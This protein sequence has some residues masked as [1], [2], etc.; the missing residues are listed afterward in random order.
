MTSHTTP[1]SGFVIRFA[2]ADDSGAAADVA[3]LA[4]LD[5]VA[6]SPAAPY[7]IAERDGL[8]VAA[9]SLSEGVTVAN[10]FLPTAD[11]VALLALRAEQVH[12]ALPS[13]RSWRRP[14]LR[15]R[16]AVS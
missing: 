4:T 13:R 11:A 2:G 12:G 6:H 15:G 9:R 16:L 3:R 10:P 5:S 7:I 14:L 1:S 8:A